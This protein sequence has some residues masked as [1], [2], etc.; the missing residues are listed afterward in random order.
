MEEERG[1]VFLIQ[2]YSIQDGPG[3]RTTIFM[4]GCPLRCQWCQNPES[5]KPHPELMIRDTKCML[6]GKCVEVCPVGA[7]TLDR[8]QSRKI[9]RSK[10][11]LCFQCVDACP[12]KA[13]SKVGEYLTVKEVVAEIERD[14][15][16]YHRSGGGVTISGGE[17]LLQWQ[18]VHRLLEACKQRHLHTAL[19][20]CGYVHWPIL[21]KVIEHVDLVLYDIKHMDPELHKKATGKSNRLILRNVRMIPPQTKVW[22]R[23]PLI[24]GFNDSTENLTELSRLG[25]EIGVEKVSILP[26]HRLAEEKYRQLGTQRKMSRIKPPSKKR[27]QKIQEL[28]ESFD[29]Q[30]TIGS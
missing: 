3:L 21:K 5:L 4:K 16:F 24:P 26:Y 10:C 25:R 15:L 19:D 8:Q 14:E 2:R 18:F 9:D 7:I 12:T 17:P 28:I 11:D 23:L 22:L 27:L 1:L 6:L 30:V 29:L 13:L 20:T